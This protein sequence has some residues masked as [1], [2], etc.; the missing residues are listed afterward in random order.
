[1]EEETWKV[2]DESELATVAATVRDRLADAV[3]GERATVLALSGDL[4]AGKTTFVQHL[5]R[6]LGVADTITSPTFVIMKRYHT[7]D[8]DFHTLI[9]I[10]AYRLE[11]VDE[12][13]VL[14]F[15]HLLKEKGT[16]ICIEWPERVA[17]LVPPHAA[18]LSFEIDGTHRTLELKT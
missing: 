14:G 2:T 12:L 15:D 4:G 5:A 6:T 1:M 8:A 7:T 16:I 3:T 11:S 17:A 10:D 18:H 9:H 13:T